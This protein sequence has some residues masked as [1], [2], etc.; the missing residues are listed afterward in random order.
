MRP[1]GSGVAFNAWG[2]KQEG[3][4]R[5]AS[6][7][8]ADAPAFGPDERSGRTPALPYPLTRRGPGYGKEPTEERKKS[9]GW[10]RFVLDGGV[11]FMDSHGWSDAIP[12]AAEPVEGGAE[13]RSHP[14]GSE[15]SA[16]STADH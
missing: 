14:E 5:E 16:G 9:V 15:E 4:K 8:W 2:Q 12:G 7:S 10:A 13:V 11:P 1:S 6:A 3:D